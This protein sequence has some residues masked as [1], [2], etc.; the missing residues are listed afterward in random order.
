MQE[1]LL[2]SVREASRLVFPFIAAKTMSAWFAEGILRPIGYPG[3]VG[4]GQGVKLDFW[5]LISVG[6]MH[7]LLAAGV[8]FGSLKI[9]GNA[10]DEARLGFQKRVSGSGPFWKLVEYDTVDSLGPRAVQEYLR[11][12]HFGVIVSIEFKRPSDVGY[13]TAHP[14]VGVL[15]GSPVGRCIAYIRFAPLR[16][17]AHYV[18][19]VGGT[20]A[21]RFT[22]INCVHWGQFV[23]HKVWALP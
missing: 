19:R 15:G 13:P 22:F 3:G 14:A 7:S 11:Q 6:V 12:H 18:G 1:G 20:P 5:D 21:E 4:P 10:F 16:D 8:R 23:Q 2:L 9:R 17:M